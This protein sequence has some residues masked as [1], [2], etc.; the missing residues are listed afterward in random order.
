MC[1]IRLSRCLNLFI[2]VWL[3]STPVVTAKT[4]IVSEN[5]QKTNV[6]LDRFWRFES[7]IK[8]EMP[9][10]N[11]VRDPKQAEIYILMTEQSTGGGNEYTLTFTGQET[12]QGV[13]DTLKYVL[14]QD[15]TE[16]IIRNKTIDYLKMGLIQYVAKTPLADAI[17][18]DFRDLQ[19]ESMPL[20]TEDKWDYWVFRI[21][22]RS[23][24]EGEEQYREVSIGGGISAN[25]IT[26]EWKINLSLNPDY[27][28]SKNETSYGTFS[29]FRKEN[30]L[31][32][33]IVNSLSENWSAGM[34]TEIVSDTRINTR[35]SAAFGPAIEYNI[36]PYSLSTRRQCTFRWGLWGNHT[37]YREET[38]FDKTKEFLYYSTFSIGAEIIDRW[39][40]LESTL[41]GKLYFHDTSFNKLDWETRVDFRIFQGF[42][43]DFG[44]RLSLIHDQLYIAKGDR[45]ID[46]ILLRR[47]QLKT[48]WSYD[49]WFGFSYLFGSPYNNIV[50]SRFGDAGR[51]GGGGDWH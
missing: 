24:I 16:D 38:L 20:Q 3:L 6:F 45:P 48:N 49:T 2:F 18:I 44:A 10:F 23:S 4:Q 25:R 7:H 47:T 22:S 27:S 21:N 51:G 40:E 37:S 26:D 11:Y 31:N 1:L 12:F 15:D 28:E 30:R 8:I 17:S 34:I 43:L 19:Q 35:L 42:S 13:N 14:R 29:T 5:L 9:F 50:N 39:G 33:L 32:G 36:F 41:E 46:E